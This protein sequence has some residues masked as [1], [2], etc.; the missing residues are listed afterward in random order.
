MFSF[1]K[2]LLTDSGARRSSNRANFSQMNIV[3]IS[4]ANFD[5]VLLTY[6]WLK[7]LFLKKVKPF[8]VNRFYLNLVKTVYV[9]P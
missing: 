8:L 3:N 1:E 7:F 2:I 5:Y 9:Y 4:R 6:P